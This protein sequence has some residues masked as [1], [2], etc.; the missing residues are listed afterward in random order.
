MLDLM[1]HL[2]R[3]QA[4]VEE[5]SLRRAAERLSITQPALSRSLAKLEKRFGR[6]LLERGARGV[7][8]TAFGAKVLS[9]VL[10]L[11]RHWELAEQELQSSNTSKKMRLRI[12]AGPLWRAVV[13]PGLIGELQRAFPN[14]V[15]ELQN[16]DFETAIPDLLE[17]RVD[18]FF[19]G[20][21]IADEVDKRLSRKQFTV[22]HDRVVARADHPLFGR[23]R[24]NGSLE[25]QVLLDYPWLIYSND[26]AYES[27]TVH[28]SIERLGRTPEIRITCESLISAIGLLQKS[29]CL[30]ILPDAAV[31][32]A[33]GPQIIPVPVQL[34]RKRTRSGAIFR[35]EMADWPPLE[36]LLALCSARFASIEPVS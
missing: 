32:E 19:G 10:R 24:P 13:L 36:Y 31:T 20:L 1:T 7:T 17:G 5:G 6:P 4:I 34:G 14:L 9:S 29:D 23:L 25:P 22:V 16:A 2:F 12:R 26:P 15:I 30:S 21:Q 3:L 8:P 18:V 33:R 35:D 27:A 28:A 11:S